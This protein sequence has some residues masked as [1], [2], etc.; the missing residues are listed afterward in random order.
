MEFASYISGF[1]D[2]EGTF[3]ISFSLRKKFTLGLEVRPSFSISQHKRNLETLK[4]I[5]KYFGVGAIRFS[6]RDQNYKYEVRS[7]SDI[8]KR[9]IPHFERYP[10]KTTKTNDFRI[11][12]KIC[13]EITLGNHLKSGHLKG[14][15]TQ[16][17]RMNESGKRKYEISYLLKLITRWRYSLNSCESNWQHVFRSSDLHE[18]RHE[19][20]TVLSFYSAKLRWLWRRG[21]FPLGQK[22]PVELYCK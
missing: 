21:L 1:T 8:V 19:L 2:G 17:Y 12:K 5:Q 10:L 20:I 7:I 16:A 13:K 22:D 18:W 9:I 15:I 4:S 3:S 11:F 14:I 6:K